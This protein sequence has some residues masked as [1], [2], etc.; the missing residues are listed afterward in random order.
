ME[1]AALDSLPSLQQ[2]WADHAVKWWSLSILSNEVAMD[3]K[4]SFTMQRMNF[5]LPLASLLQIYH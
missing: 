1:K 3:K 4:L 2:D 5:S